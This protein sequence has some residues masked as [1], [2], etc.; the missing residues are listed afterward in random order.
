MASIKLSLRKEADKYLQELDQQIS[1][2]DELARNPFSLYDKKGWE[3]ASD[4]LRTVCDNAASEI[5]NI[6]RKYS[7]YG[8]TD[9][10][11]REAIQTYVSDAI[12]Q[13]L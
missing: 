1:A 3:Q 12:H 5:G 6:A 2:D 7:R 13:A 9:T 4:S 11:S 10:A 8:A